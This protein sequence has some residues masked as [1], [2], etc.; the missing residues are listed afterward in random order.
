[1]MI[2][3]CSQPLYGYGANK[4]LASEKEEIKCSSKIKGYNKWLILMML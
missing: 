4:D 3:E 1:M 2:K